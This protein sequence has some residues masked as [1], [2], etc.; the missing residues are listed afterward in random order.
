M[1]VPV[2]VR[3]VA[4]CYTPFT[5][6]TL[7]SARLVLGV[8]HSKF[9]MRLFT[10][11]FAKWNSVQS[12]RRK[13][14]FSRSSHLFRSQSR[15]WSWTHFVA[16]TGQSITILRLCKH[17]YTRMSSWMHG[18]CDNLSPSLIS[19]YCLCLCLL[20]YRRTNEFL[21]R[22]ARMLWGGLFLHT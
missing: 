17:L 6:F 11:Q 18:Y 12:V 16:S 5:Y 10:L 7:L 1:W 21:G 19:H 20:C 22:M 4:N 15:P 9:P 2:A 8:M 13:Q 14:A 3:R